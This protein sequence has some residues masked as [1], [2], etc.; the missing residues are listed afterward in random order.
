MDTRA[1]TILVVNSASGSYSEQAVIAVRAALGKGD[2]AMI[3]TYDCRSDEVP[4]RCGLE[5][6]GTNLLAVFA[7]DGTIS[8]H[9][10]RLEAEG[11]QGT[12]LPLPGG[13][14]NLLSTAMFGKLSATEIAAMAARGELAGTRRQ[15]LRCEGHTALAEILC[16]PGARW[17]DVRE[18]LRAR[19]MGEAAA[20]SLDITREA[21]GGA[22]VRLVEPV[23]G[24]TDG[25]PGLH[26]SLSGGRMIARG[27]RMANLAD[28]IRQGWAM[29]TR[30]FREGPFD[31]LGTMDRARCAA[32]PPDD[33][34]DTA[35][36]PHID[37]M[38][39]GERETAG[40][41]AL[42]VREPFGLTFLGLDR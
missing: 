15:C 35:E 30:D 29:A 25:Y 8:R 26:F 18:D 20:K 41:E 17:A 13:T 40:A 10:V 32:C 39:D 6:S 11:W 37:L 1:R 24:R 34:P 4:G 7:G 42:V 31:E 19:E 5:A 14:Q 27:Y 23:R 33:P 12:V 28:W 22:L 16:G 9:F 36:E 3:R 21:V 2:A 38:I